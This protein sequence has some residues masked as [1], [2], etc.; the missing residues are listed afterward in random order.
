M[1]VDGVLLNS[2]IFYNIFHYT[3]ETISRK[4]TKTTLCFV[5]CLRSCSIDM[6]GCAVLDQSK[7][8]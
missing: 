4:L 8:L 3:S 7:I 1:D 6:F 2:Y 5:I